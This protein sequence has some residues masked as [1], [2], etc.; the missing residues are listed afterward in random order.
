MDFNYIYTIVQPQFSR[1]D[2]FSHCLQILWRIN[3]PP[4]DEDLGCVIWDMLPQRENESVIL[5]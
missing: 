1:S 3:L 5:S 4:W 2:T